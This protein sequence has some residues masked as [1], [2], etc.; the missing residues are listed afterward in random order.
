MEFL[1]D[2]LPY[3]IGLALIA[4]VLV[5]FTGMF[6]MGKGGAFNDRYGNLLMRLRVGTQA[7][8]VLLMLAYFLLTRAG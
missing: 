7:A 3:A 5:L 8:A 2:V 4:V 1:I 6:A